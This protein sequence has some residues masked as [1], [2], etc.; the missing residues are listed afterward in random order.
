MARSWASYKEA[1]SGHMG[2]CTRR[3]NMG[4]SMSLEKSIF[5]W[6]CSHYRNCRDIADCGSTL[7]SYS[8]KPELLINIE[9]K[10]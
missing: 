2:N 5:I 10:K 4:G 3:Q 7:I 6:D 1:M 8:L 9:V